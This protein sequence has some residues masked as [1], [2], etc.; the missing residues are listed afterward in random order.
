MIEHATYSPNHT[1]QRFIQ[2]YMIMSVPKGE[3]LKTFRNAKL[4][5]A[6]LFHFVKMSDAIPT[7]YSYQL[8]K[9]HLFYN[10]QSWLEENR[11]ETT[12]FQNDENRHTFCAVFTPIGV[13]Y[14]LH[15]N[16]TIRL[17]KGFSFEII[18]LDKQF[19][20]LTEKIQTI[21]DFNEAIQLVE[22]YFLIYFSHLDIP[23]SN[24][25]MAPIA[26]YILEKNGVVKIAEL[27]DKFHISRRWLE[28]QFA[29]QVGMSPKDFA[30]VTRFNAL[31]TEVKK[32]PSVSWLDMIDKFGYYDQS[33]LIRDFHDFTGQ[34]PT[35]FFK[36]STEVKN[37]I[38]YYSLK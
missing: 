33:H 14:L 10:H 7:S 25:D 29:E 37:G 3:M 32:Y 16:S 38:F 36:D 1:L 22:S 28:K 9:K 34:F 20:G 26:D 23:L 24:T 35:E 2:M 17:N 6:L 18:G 30:R 31:I 5:S 4:Y 27:E 21:S 11:E 8:N 19:E 15:N 12:F 13:H